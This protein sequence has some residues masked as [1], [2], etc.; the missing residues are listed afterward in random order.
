MNE[1]ERLLRENKRLEAAKIQI[2]QF[3]LVLVRNDLDFTGVVDM[4]LK[5]RLG[6][7]T[8][9]IVNKSQ[10]DLDWVGLSEFLNKTN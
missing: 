1:P 6:R 8:G 4:K 2:E 3:L 7:F 5:Y 9:G 10:Q